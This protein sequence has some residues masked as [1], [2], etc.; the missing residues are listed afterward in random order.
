MGVYGVQGWVKVFS[1]T[2]PRRNIV[3]FPGWWLRQHGEWRRVALKQGKEQGK[4]VVA[5]LEGVSDRDQAALLQGSEIAVDRVELPALEEGYYWTD[6]IGCEVRT[7]GGQSI[8]QV[9]RLFE[10]GANDVMVAGQPGASSQ[11]E[12]L[13]P[14]V[15]PDV[16]VDVD[17]AQRVVTVDWDLEWLSST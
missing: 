3:G 11:D 5:L 17:L 4:H 12:I 16:I 8:G 6:L 13:I 15:R 7:E 1:E 14:W 9:L 10:T 2:Q